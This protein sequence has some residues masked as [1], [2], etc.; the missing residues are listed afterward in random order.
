MSG[1]LF[2]ILTLLIMAVSMPAHAASITIDQCGSCGNPGQGLQIVTTGVNPGDF[3]AIGLVN[4]TFSYNPAPVASGGQG[5][6]ISIDASVDKN[7]TI[8]QNNPFT[9]SIGNGF[10]PLIEQ[11]GKFYMASVSVTILDTGAVPVTSISSGYLLKRG[12][13]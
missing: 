2:A 6:I 11:D 10:R 5:P 7:L 13:R 3:M 4:T 1:A 8:S 9:A 12:R